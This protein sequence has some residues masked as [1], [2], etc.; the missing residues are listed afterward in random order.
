MSVKAKIKDDILEQ[1]RTISYEASGQQIAAK[2]GVSR[3]AVWKAIG[4]LRDE[5]FL[6]EGT[7]GRGYKLCGEKYMSESLMRKYLKRELPIT[8]LKSTAS[9]S[10]LAKAAAEDG[11]PEGSVF[12]AE[13][14]LSGRGRTGKSFYSPPGTG[15]YMSMV[16][17]PSMPATEALK[18]T[19]CA[20]VAVS[21]AIEEVTGK[22]ASIKWVN[23]LFYNNLKICGILTEASF[24]ME[25]GGLNYAV[26]GIGINVLAPKDGF[27]ELSHIAGALMPYSENAGEIRSRLAAAICDTFLKK[28]TQMNSTELFEGYRRRLFVYGKKVSVINGANIRSATVLG[29][30]KDYK[31]IVRYEN[32]EVE[33]LSSGEIS[34]IPE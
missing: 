14:Q 10:D 17:R 34:I 11:A 9:T 23:D 24:N 18:I 12:I 1:F 7:S 32:G 21:E 22:R 29:I 31:L 3:N 27:G 26:L 2:L 30:E 20:A 15:I 4:E 28:Y 19:T 6:I 33:S 8:L 25:N 5:G 16:L 13:T